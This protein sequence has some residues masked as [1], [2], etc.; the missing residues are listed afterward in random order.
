MSMLMQDELGLIAR[1][2]LADLERARPGF[3]LD[4][5][6]FT[7]ATRQRVRLRLADLR[8]Q[9]ASV[10]SDADFERVAREIDEVLVR[11]YV[12][13]ALA[14]AGRERRGGGGWRGGDII[15]RVVLGLLG[16]IVGAYL[17][18][19]LPVYEKWIPLVLMA[20][21][22]FIPDLQQRWHAHRHARE[23]QTL[24]LDM[25][26]AGRAL[27]DSRPLSGM[28]GVSGV[29]GVATDSARAA[30]ATKAGEGQGS[31]T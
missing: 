6:G 4:A 20:A 11:R 12:T 9:Y 26:R 30:A 27:A 2:L 17:V 21:A 19:V 3:A 7:E 1:D 18:R 5:A 31:R 29:S 14:Q 10:G 23:L 8:A 16:F 25:Q 24:E 22:P 15:G 13:F 28:S